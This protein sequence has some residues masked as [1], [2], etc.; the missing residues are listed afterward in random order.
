MYSESKIW[1]NG[2]SNPK[3][4]FKLC[5]QNAFDTCLIDWFRRSCSIAGKTYTLQKNMVHR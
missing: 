1:K 4:I 5:T 2:Y 3:V